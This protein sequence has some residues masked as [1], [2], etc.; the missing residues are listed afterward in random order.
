MHLAV[1]SSGSTRAALGVGGKQ[2]PLQSLLL[3][4]TGLDNWLPVFCRSCMLA[5]TLVPHCFL[6]GE[7]C[8]ELI[9]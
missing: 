2:R 9:V 7:A 3:S 1:G 8:D 4:Y 5:W 6:G